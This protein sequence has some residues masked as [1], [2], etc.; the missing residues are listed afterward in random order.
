MKFN[1]KD[2]LILVIP[3]IIIIISTPFLPDQIPMQWNYNGDVNWYL[4]KRLSFLL[5]FIP[6]IVYK[7]YKAK[8]GYK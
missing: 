2:I 1:K 8:R 6:F 5:G 7:S 4:N 3:I